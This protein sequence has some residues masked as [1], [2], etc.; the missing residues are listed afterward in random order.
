ML[1]SHIRGNFQALSTVQHRKLSTGKR[2]KGARLCSKYLPGLHAWYA[3]SK[4]EVKERERDAKHF[5]KY[6]KF[7]Q[8]AAIVRTRMARFLKSYIRISWI[9]YTHF[10]LII[11]E[12][13]SLLDFYTNAI[14]LLHCHKIGKNQKNLASL[15]SYHIFKEWNNKINKNKIYDTT[16]FSIKIEIL[17]GVVA[18]LYIAVST[19]KPWLHDFTIPRACKCYTIFCLDIFSIVIDKILKK[20]LKWVQYHWYIE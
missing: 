4:R 2:T 3:S 15:L 10:K 17:S 11:W 16:K 8:S 9:A 14:S 13:K 1:E 20:R 7:C 5:G 19:R 6:W 12:Q 18:V